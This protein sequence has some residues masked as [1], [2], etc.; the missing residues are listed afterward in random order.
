MGVGHL[1]A[2]AAVSSALHESDPLIETKI[3]DSYKY[4]ASM[5]SKVVANGYIEMV[6]TIPQMYR[7]LY[8]RAEKA[9]EVGRFRTWVHQFTAT[10]LR[11]VIAEIKPDVVACTHAFPCGVMSEYKKQ[12]ED[13]PP[14]VGIVTD[15]V[16][17]SFWIHRNIDGYAVATQEMRNALVARGVPAERV[18]VSG[19]PVN[20]LF[21]KHSEDR[22]RLRA[23]L[24]LPLDRHVVLIMGGGLGLGP[25]EM[26]MRALNAVQEP[27]SAVV[28][29]GKNARLEHRVFEAAQRM[30]YPLRIVHFID[31]VYD[32]MHASDL[33]LSKPGGL[34]TAEALVANLPMVLVKPLPGQEERNTRFLV[35]R[36]AAVRSRSQVHLTRIVEDL[37]ASPQSLAT[38][39]ASLGALA[40][41]H[42]ACEVAA[43]IASVSRGGARHVAV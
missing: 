6:K 3:I 41:P 10:N 32:Y 35:D 1:S 2:A 34:T 14:V 26:M 42:A 36:K 31:N 23:E 29:L 4:A 24:A 19:I 28:I 40:R 9:T 7:F 22:T 13:A 8:N 16:V 39:R 43:L 27:L 17:H 25:L 30:N 20:G 38:M 18:I 11:S 33:L 15:F 21:A 12:F 5:V 37:L